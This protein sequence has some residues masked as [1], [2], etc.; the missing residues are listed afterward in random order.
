MQNYET[1]GKCKYE[2]KISEMV[3]HFM[4][5]ETKFWSFSGVYGKLD[6]K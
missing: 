1:I 4:I 5:N 3:L 2:N 6:K